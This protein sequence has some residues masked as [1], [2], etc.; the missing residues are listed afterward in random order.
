MIDILVASLDGYLRAGYLIL[1]MGLLALVAYA[2]D[3]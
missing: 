3:N 2:E 1:I